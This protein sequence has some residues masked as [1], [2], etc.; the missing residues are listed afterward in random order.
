MVVPVASPATAAGVP[1]LTDPEGLAVAGDGSVVIADGFTNQVL[2]LRGGGLQVVAGS[3]RA[4][5]A[6]DGGPATR[7]EL[8]Q[9]EGLAVGTD[10]TIYVADDANN[11]VRA[12]SPAGIIRTIAGNGIRGS[13]GLGGAA[14]A[15]ELDGPRALALGPDGSIDVT[16]S[17]AVDKI[18]P[19]GRLTEAIRGG[20]AAFE[21]TGTA[22]ATNETGGGTA[23]AFSPTAIALDAA[24]DQYVAGFSPKFL[25]EFSPAGHP[26]HVWENYISNPGLAAA[27]DGR[28]IAADYG[29]WA[30]ER[31]DGDNLTRVVGFLG[32]GSPLPGFRPW[33]VAVGRD[34]EIYV[35][36]GSGGGGRN[37]SALLAIDPGGHVRMIAGR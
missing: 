35:D 33:G 36:N 1:P 6:G 26:L 12:I 2:R 16:V 17:E 37:D 25:V 4:G 11:R 9:P 34:G 29:N 24:G 13:A 31:V 32:P 21:V 3:G 20:P 7:A 18:S 28:V 10:G 15:A 27:P 14:T 23:C 19:D 8:S 22:G 30:V 5:Y